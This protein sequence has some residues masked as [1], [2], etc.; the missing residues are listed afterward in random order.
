MPRLKFLSSLFLLCIFLSC[1]EPET[2][3]SN[4][5]SPDYD[6][7]LSLRT[8]DSGVNKYSASIS[9]NH[10]TEEDFGSYLIESNELSEYFTDSIYI[11]NNM[12]PGEFRQI[13]LT[14]L[15]TDFQIFQ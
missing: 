7:Q 15:N 8:T 12:S 10:Y 6:Y 5:I 11:L 3:V 13:K 9:W 1:D 2:I 4:T 14:T